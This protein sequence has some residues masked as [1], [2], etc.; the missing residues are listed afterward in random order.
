MCWSVL[1]ALYVCVLC[2]FLVHSEATIQHYISWPVV[3]DLCSFCPLP[4]TGDRL[5][6]L[7][8]ERCTF[9]SENLVLNITIGPSENKFLPFRSTPALGCLARGVSGH[10]QGPTQDTSRDPKTSGELNTASAPIQYHGT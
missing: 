1:P 8:K 9:I 10:L 2:A 5:G 6:N 3:L 4:H 7:S